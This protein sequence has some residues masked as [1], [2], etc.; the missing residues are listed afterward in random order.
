M[1]PQID[2]TA[3][4]CPPE[5]VWSAFTLA[6]LGGMA[7]SLLC[8]TVILVV[9][10]FTSDGKSQ[11]EVN[12]GNGF[13]AAASEAEEVGHAQRGAFCIHSCHYLPLLK[14]MIFNSVL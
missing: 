2:D 14:Y 4:L 10:A 3:T 13:C 12:G 8:E 6:V 1:T 11:A 7:R 5:L 9:V